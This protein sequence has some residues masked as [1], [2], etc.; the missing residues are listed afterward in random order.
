MKSSLKSH[1]CWEPLKRFFTNM[2]KKYDTGLLVLFLKRNKV[3]SLSH[4]VVSFR[5]LISLS[6]CIKNVE[7]VFNK[8]RLSIFKKIT[9]QDISIF[10]KNL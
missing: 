9:N 7:N 6:Q 1:P 3:F 10:I 2:A 5:C 4:F 8:T